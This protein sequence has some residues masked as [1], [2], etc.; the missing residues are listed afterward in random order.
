VTDVSDLT[1]DSAILREDDGDT[2]LSTCSIGT[3]RVVDARGYHINSTAAAYM[4]LSPNP[5]AETTTL[6][7]KSEGEHRRLRL[8]NTLSNV[9]KDFT[10]Q[11]TSNNASI[12]LD[13]SDL[14]AGFYLLR[15]DTGTSSYALQLAVQ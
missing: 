2:I 5:A 8:F 11:I 1:I 12:V 6:T 13:V 4:S 7:Y 3:V 15:L 9:V 10:S 14:P